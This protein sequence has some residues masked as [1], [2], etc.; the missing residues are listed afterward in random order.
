MMESQCHHQFC[1]ISLW[2]NSLH[3]TRQETAWPATGEEPFIK[4]TELTVETDGGTM[5]KGADGAQLASH[6]QKVS[7]DGSFPCKCHERA[8]NRALNLYVGQK[9]DVAN[10][11]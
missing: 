9:C 6:T 8:I 11:H 4:G 7:P 1:F 2:G 3:Q 10:K 5:M